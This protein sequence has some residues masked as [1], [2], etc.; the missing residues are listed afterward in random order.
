MPLNE[1]PTHLY[2]VYWITI[3]TTFA[4]NISRDNTQRFP[5]FHTI[6]DVWSVANALS[7]L[8]SILLHATIILWG[9]AW[10]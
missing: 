1:N 4:Q 2:V 10:G 3:F 6:N 8:G 7:V 9:Q 5:R